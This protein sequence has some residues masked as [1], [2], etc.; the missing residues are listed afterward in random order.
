MR[1][2][3]INAYEQNKHLVNHVVFLTVSGL[4]ALSVEK[5]LSKETTPFL[6][7]YKN[8]ESKCY[9]K[10]SYYFN[11]HVRILKIYLI[12]LTGIQNERFW[13][14]FFSSKQTNDINLTGQKKKKVRDL[15]SENRENIE[16]PTY[17]DILRQKYEA[18]MLSKDDLQINLY[19][20]DD[21]PVYMD[22]LRTAD[23]KP[24][25]KQ[26][27]TDMILG[28]DC[29]MVQQITRASFKQY[30]GQDCART[31]ISKIDID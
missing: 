25:G 17:E 13:E 6:E 7:K 28:V 23:Y 14:L 24:N 2:I 27:L 8:F 3:E 18:S 30:I 12:L 10:G 4:D 15:N 22:Y 26:S 21:L 11:P 16:N 31:G 9:M 19:P 20:V 29:E 5:Y 1:F